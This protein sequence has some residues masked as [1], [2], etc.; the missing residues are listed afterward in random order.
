MLIA[1]NQRLLA[2]ANE[3]TLLIQ[4]KMP[5]FCASAYY[6]KMSCEIRAKVTIASQRAIRNDEK[7]YFRR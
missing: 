5:T 2:A 6:K 1:R 4:P 3:I 7:W